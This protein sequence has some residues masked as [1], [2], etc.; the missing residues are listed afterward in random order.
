MATSK[1]PAAGSLRERILAAQDQKSELVEVPE[2]GVTVEVR[3]LSGKQRA[4]VLQTA[5]DRKGNT[6]L[7]KLYPALL[8]ET[9]FD[10]EDGE[11]VFRAEDRDAINARNSG[12]L[13]RVAQV[14]MRLS[15]IDAGA[16]ERAEKNS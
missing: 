1:K 4:H 15:G 9:V 10:P 14:A 12:A 3:S 2:W 13:E 5:V 8:V 11:R 16:Q 6:D 7:E